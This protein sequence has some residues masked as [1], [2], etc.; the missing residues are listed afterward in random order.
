[1]HENDSFTRRRGK[2]NKRLLLFKKV[3][4]Q[5]EIS[6]KNSEKRIKAAQNAAFIL[7]FSFSDPLPGTTITSYSYRIAGARIELAS[8]G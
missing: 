7:C 2:D 3:R 8:G 4:E 5:S 6:E 1:M